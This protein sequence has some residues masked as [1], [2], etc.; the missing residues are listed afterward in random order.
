[1]KPRWHHRWR[2]LAGVTDLLFVGGALIGWTLARFGA[3]AFVSSFVPARGQGFGR[4]PL[5]FAIPAWLAVFALFRLYNPPRCQNSLEEGRRLVMAG[6]AAAVAIVLLGFVVKENPARS[7]LV[8]AMVIGTLSASIGRQTLRSIV[9]SLRESGRWSTRAI[10]VGSQEGKKL[11]ELAL[12]DRSLGLDPVA[13]CGFE[14]PPLPS[15]EAGA[16]RPAVDATDAGEVVVVTEGLRRSDVAAAIE[17]ADQLPV[18]VVVV[19]GLDYLMLRSLRLVT[20]GNEPGLALDAP[21]LH[22]YQAHIKR[23]IDVA[24]GS[25]LGILTAPLMIVSAIAIR[26]ESAGPIVFRQAREGMNGKTFEVFKLRTMRNGAHK[27][28]V[29]ELRPD[30]PMFFTKPDDDPR[31]TRVGRLLRKTSID[32]L[33]QLWNVVRG[34]MSLV[35]PRPLALWEAERLGL[36]RRIV[37]RPGLTGLWQVSGRS[38]LSPE[39]RIRL[40]L[41]YVQNW[42]L[43][44]DFSILL[45]TVPAVVGRRGAF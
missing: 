32:E 33:P 8:G 2:L 23:L 21:S 38:T 18:N 40:D 27:E 19:P 20:V 16:V 31:T 44:L 22:Q 9:A 36:R 42:S 24:F 41:V 30:D 11:V 5:A 45:R 25:V 17:V 12:Q 14:L 3:G 6:P 7:W 43:L 26:V 15:W 4:A 37:V 10:V 35:G 34:D 28:L 1:M 39:E 29:A 13:T